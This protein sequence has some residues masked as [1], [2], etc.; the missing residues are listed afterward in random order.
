MRRDY[1][2]VEVTNV[3]SAGIPSLDI[4]YDGPRDQ[5]VGRLTDGTGDPL[6]AEELDVTYRLQSNER[7]VIGITNRVT[8]EFLVE[9]N[10]DNEAV[11]AFIRAARDEGG[12]DETRYRL[13]IHH[14]GDELLSHEKGTLLVYDAGGDL[15]RSESLIPSG[16][17]L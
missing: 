16:V 6:A 11:L 4:E 2:T 5:L 8:G 10:A 14:D 12:D 9:V 15:R 1:F 7:G 17:E 3:D 13:R